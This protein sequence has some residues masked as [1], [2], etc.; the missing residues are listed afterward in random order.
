MW[1]SGWV[2][3]FWSGWGGRGSGGGYRVLLDVEDKDCVF[4]LTARRNSQNDRQVTWDGIRIKK[5]RDM[6]IKMA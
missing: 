4:E 5:R 3:G 1:M 2:D 6:H